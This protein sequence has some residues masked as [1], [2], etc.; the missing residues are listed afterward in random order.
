MKVYKSLLSIF[1]LSLLLTGCGSPSGDKKSE[2][3][4]PQGDNTPVTPDPS[5]EGEGGEV[6]PKQ[7][8]FIPDVGEVRLLFDHGTAGETRIYNYCPSIFIDENNQEHVYY[9]SNK[10]E[11]NVT[12]YIA[13]RKGV[14]ANNQIKYSNVNFVLDSVNFVKRVSSSVS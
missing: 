14:I 9:C 8:S 3:E 2:G 12:D 1:G 11:G 7:A 5:G 10:D 13:Y 6:T 4:T